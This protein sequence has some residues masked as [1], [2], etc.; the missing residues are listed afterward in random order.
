MVGGRFDAVCDYR[1]MNSFDFLLILVMLAF[2][3]IGALRGMVR[4]VLSLVTWILSG[5][6]AWLFA[7]SI[8]SLFSDMIANSEL[9]LVAAFVVLFVLVFIVG[10]VVTFT[11]HKMIVARRAFRI[12]NLVFGGMIGLARGMVVVV[13][14]FLLAG[15]TS[16]PQRPW[17]REAAL[18]PFFQKFALFVGEYLPKDVA[19]H[20]RYG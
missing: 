5:L 11:V 13:I 12:P 8:E 16:V 1:F 17:W 15:I 10:T 4:E 20:I 19:R 7:G 9:R 14:V 6:I 2:T 18:A 3:A